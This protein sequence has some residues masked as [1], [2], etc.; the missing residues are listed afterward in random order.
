MSS[1]SE[2]ELIVSF[3]I[4]HGV[5]FLVIGGQAEHLMGSPRVT[6]DIDLCYRR[7]KDN[8]ER[9]ALALKDLKPTSVMLHLICRSL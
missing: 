3:F 1:D 7:T 4:R 9:L 8:L 2:L 5:E 6:Y